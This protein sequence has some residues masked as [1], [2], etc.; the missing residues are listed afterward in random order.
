MAENQQVTHLYHLTNSSNVIGKTLFENGGLQGKKVLSVN[1]DKKCLY[2]K[3]MSMN[4]ESI[5]KLFHPTLNFDCQ[6][7]NSF[8]RSII[9]LPKNQQWTILLSIILFDGIL[10]NDELVDEIRENGKI[11]EI[12]FFM[13]VEEWTTN[14]YVA[15]TVDELNRF[16]DALLSSS[17]LFYQIKYDFFD[18]KEVML[19]MIDLYS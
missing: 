17:R 1:G 14:C 15:V 8:K 6:N 5:E 16:V 9:K 3:I 4:E 7:W 13:S 10:F 2:E 18:Y 19:F 11:T 12:D